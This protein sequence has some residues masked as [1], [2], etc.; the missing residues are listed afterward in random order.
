[1]HLG[2]LTAAGLAAAALASAHEPAASAAR[3]IGPAPP[4]AEGVREQAAE[5]LA[6]SFVP[7]R[8]RRG[9]VEGEPTPPARA[10]VAPGYAPPDRGAG[11][12]LNGTDDVLVVAER[13]G[14]LA[15]LLP[16]RELTASAWVALERSQRWGGILSNVQDQGS[17]ERG[18]VLGYEESNF[19]FGLS[20]VGADDGDGLLT[21]LRGKT[22]MT[23]G[24]WH[25]VVAT[26]DGEVARLF[27]DGELDAETSVQSGDLLLD[28]ASPLVIGAYRDAD[29]D[30]PMDGRLLSVALE[31]RAWEAREVRAA[32]E[33]FARRTEL[34]PW[35]DLE[36]GFLV[37]PFLTWPAT[38]AMSVTFE[39]TFPT[40]AEV[41]Y[42]RDDQT[43]EELV[44]FT[45]PEADL[46]HE[47]RLT[48]LEP[49]SKYFYRVH[50]EAVDGSPL[51]SP[52]LSFRTA[53]SPGKAF[54]FVVVG[55]TQ[56]NG[57][58][59]KRVSDLAWMHRPN[60]VVHAGDLVDTGTNKRD[61][62]DVFFPSM[63]PLI[64]RVPMMPVLGNHEQ[65]AEHYYR[66]MSLPQPE[67]W[68]S[69]T[70]GDAEFFMIDGNRSL[71]DQSAQLEWLEGALAASKATWRFAVLHQPPYTSDADD[72]GDTWTTTSH[73]GDPNVQ[74]IIGAL[75]RHGVDICFSGHVHDYERTFPILN[76]QVT[77]YEDGGVI[78]VTAA[79]AGG[80]LEDFD[81]TN[82][83][84]GHKKARYHHLVYVGIHGDQLEFQAIDQHGKLFDTLTLTKRP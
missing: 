27:V 40:T 1:M 72:Y 52:L 60:L 2:L 80:S 34:A 81:P 31:P 6:W 38:D 68:Y 21:Y 77:A 49:D 73:R 43:E 26:Y 29:E 54:T 8:A 63:Q 66:Y 83:W 28:P 76:E 45:S 79:G 61:W 32:F 13:A 41:R 10:L 50:A 22:D 14:D 30:F 48:G 17:S 44:T 55:D 64:G 47:C 23:P 67:R 46:L 62:T 33:R 9:F 12:V 56:H 36:L 69:F 7:E 65:D 82:T 84:F 78:Y 70:Y 18:W 37:E 39:T 4:L 15:G 74:G 35:T 57:T 11:L 75:E 42:R 24:R 71:A 20:T 3:S 5:S 25:H 51:E 59:A 16:T 58:V 19:S 53:S